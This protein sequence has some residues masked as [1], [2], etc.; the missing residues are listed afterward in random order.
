MKDK[1]YVYRE[2]FWEN[3]KRIIIPSCLCICN[4]CEC[5]KESGWW[6]LRN[7]KWESFRDDEKGEITHYTD[8]DYSVTLGVMCLPKFVLLQHLWTLNGLWQAALLRK[9]W[10]SAEN[11]PFKGDSIDIRFISSSVSVSH[12]FLLFI[13]EVGF[14]TSADFLGS[15]DYFFC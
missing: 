2:S 11:F 5:L 13:C 7:V 14:D 4:K 9:D 10:E 6:T 8:Y 3:V 15:E 1:D 12:L